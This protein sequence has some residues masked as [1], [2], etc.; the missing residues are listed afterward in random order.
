MSADEQGDK[1]RA[2]E[3]DRLTSCMWV[4]VFKWENQFE[5]INTFSQTHS[6]KET[7]T[8]TEQDTLKNTANSRDPCTQENSL[9]PS[10]TVTTM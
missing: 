4:S 8:Q 7:H 9:F 3:P 10:Q 5:C 6:N 2:A 1:H